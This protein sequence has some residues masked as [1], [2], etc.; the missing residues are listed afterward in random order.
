MFKILTK[1]KYNDSPMP[2][3]FRQKIFLTFFSF[4]LQ[5]FCYCC[6]ISFFSIISSCRNSPLIFLSS[7]RFFRFV[8][9][10]FFIVYLFWF[11]WKQRN[12]KIIKQTTKINALLLKEKTRSIWSNSQNELSSLCR[13]RSIDDDEKTTTTTAA[14]VAVTLEHDSRCDSEL[15]WWATQFTISI[16]FKSK[17]MK[18]FQIISVKLFIY[19]KSFGLAK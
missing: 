13:A 17:S 8:S 4:V 3:W 6:M 5:I 16:T 11:E 14:T 19:W 18:L 10:F 2:T 7:Y 1:Q 15:Q 9:F 12:E